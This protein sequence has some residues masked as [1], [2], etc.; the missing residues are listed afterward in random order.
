[1]RSN[2]Q[3]SMSID[4]VTKKIVAKNK[5]TGSEYVFAEL[6]AYAPHICRVSTEAGGDQV[7]LARTR[8]IEFLQPCSTI[9]RGRVGVRTHQFAAQGAACSFVARSKK[10]TEVIRARQRPKINVD[11]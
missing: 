5:K 9:T 4:A 6:V 11:R 2:D 1:V 10:T 3:K 7:W 8:Q